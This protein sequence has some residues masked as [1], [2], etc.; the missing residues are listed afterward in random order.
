[1]HIQTKTRFSVMNLVDLAGSER[2]KESKG[3]H[4]ESSHINRSLFVLTNVIN[5][6]AKSKQGYIPYRDSKLT[7]VLSNSLGGNC[8]T[9]IICTIAPDIG[10]I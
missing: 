3:Q 8:L 7:R 9:A 6:L 10:N 1:M 2:L 4:N 5:R